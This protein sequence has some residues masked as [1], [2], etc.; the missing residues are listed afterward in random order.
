MIKDK[1]CVWIISSDLETVGRR[2]CCRYEYEALNKAQEL[3]PKASRW[4]VKLGNSIDTLLF[5]VGCGVK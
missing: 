3:W 4:L 5:A 2:F 1:Y